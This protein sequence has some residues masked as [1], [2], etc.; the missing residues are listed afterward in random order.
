MRS[1]GEV[2]SLMG[3]NYEVV[4]ATK[5]KDLPGGGNK[6]PTVVWTM[7]VMDPQG[8]FHDVEMLRPQEPTVGESIE[9]HIETNEYG[10]KLVRDQASGWSGGGGKSPDQQRSIVRQH[11]QEMALRYLAAKN[12]QSFSLDDDFRKVIQWFADDAGGS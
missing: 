9:G 12:V 6:R 3:V 7:R 2:L 8:E 10:K 4:S 5:K 1:I 11:S